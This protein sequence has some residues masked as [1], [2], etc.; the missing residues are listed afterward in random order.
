MTAVVRA[1]ADRELLIVPDDCEHVLGSAGRAVVMMTE[2]CRRVRIIA[3]S[4][5]RLDVP[6]ELVFPAALDEA[7][8]V[9]AARPDRFAETIVR[10]L[11][12]DLFAALGHFEAAE[13]EVRLCLTAGRDGAVRVGEGRRNDAIARRLFIAP[14]TVKVHLTHIFAKL[15][16]TTRTELAAQA[17]AHDPT[18]R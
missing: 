15:G 7:A 9:L 5:E 16:V 4:R 12:A 18:A 17:A 11:R 3:T 14:G 10:R 2:Q 13:T 8:T 6:G 1:L